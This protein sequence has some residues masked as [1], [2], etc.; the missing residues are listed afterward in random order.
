MAIRKIFQADDEAL[1]KVCK[2]VTEV[3]D[4]I[5]ILI[6]DLSETMEKAQGVGLAAPQVGIL[7]RVWL[8]WNVC[9]RGW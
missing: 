8:L 2:P 4:R 5:R 6:D 1:H 9:N 7:R 3:N